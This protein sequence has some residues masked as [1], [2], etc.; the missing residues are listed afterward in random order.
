MR[1]WVDFPLPSCHS[2][3]MSVPGRTS[4]GKNGLSFSSPFVS[5]I[6]CAVKRTFPFFARDGAVADGFS[7]VVA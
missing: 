2:T 6:L 1:T 4:F 3:T 7:A 5:E